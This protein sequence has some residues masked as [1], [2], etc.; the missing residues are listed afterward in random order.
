MSD[1]TVTENFKAAAKAKLVAETKK[2]TLPIQDHVLIGLAAYAGVKGSFEAIQLGLKLNELL[3]QKIYSAMC[4]KT[5]LNF[6]Y[7]NQFVLDAKGPSNVA[8]HW[9]LTD[10]GI[11]AVC[12]KIGMQIPVGSGK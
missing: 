11:A 10:A 8:N 9:R 4:G 6:K 7:K 3:G 5:L 2:R 12:E 1:G